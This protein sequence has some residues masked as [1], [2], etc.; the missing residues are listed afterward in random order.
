MGKL[1]G[2]IMSKP[3]AITALDAATNMTM[4]SLRQIGAVNLNWHYWQKSHSDRSSMDG[5]NDQL[6]THEK[7]RLGSPC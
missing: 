3:N 2:V 5:L 1:H 7:R 6:Q 4:I